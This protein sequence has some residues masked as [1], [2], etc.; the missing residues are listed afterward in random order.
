MPSGAVRGAAIFD[1]TGAYRYAL[2]RSWARGQRA[3]FVMLN[4]NTADAV[5]DD[6]T[7]RRCVGF[8]RRWGCGSLDVV[9]LFAYR[10]V[11]PRVLARVADPVGPEN[12]RHLAR[13]IRGADLV[14]YAWGAF[15]L[16]RERAERL[17]ATLGGT[18][19]LC[20]GLTRTGAPRHPLYLRA[21][22]ALRPI[23]G[24]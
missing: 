11:D 2:R 3:A 1:P 9:N 12:D 19:A 21:D 18:P 10:T 14:V 16:A 15:P 20:L 7:I 13:A 5:R 8:A 22:T 23:S 4:P 17:A 24:W 6:P